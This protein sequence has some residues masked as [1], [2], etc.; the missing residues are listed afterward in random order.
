AAE[1][2]PFEGRITDSAGLLDE[3][4]KANLNDL[5]ADYEHKTDNQIFILTVRNLGGEDIEGFSNRAFRAYKIGDPKKNNG[6]LLVIAKED[7]RIRIEVG[8]GLEGVLPD[9]RA[10]QI[11]RE[12]ITPYFKQGNYSGGTEAGVREIMK[13]VSPDYQQPAS[14]QPALR[15]QPSRKHGS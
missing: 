3:R 14:N 8:Y 10:G 5:L 1:L 12:E 11:I 9:G 15:R 4:G 7:R 13:V 2:P 6:V